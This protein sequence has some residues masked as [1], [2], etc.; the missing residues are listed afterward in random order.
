MS[1]LKEK[2]AEKTIYVSINNGK[3][4][5][6]QAD[7][8]TKEY[9]SVEGHIRKVDFVIEEYN[10]QKFEK[11]KFYINAVGELLILQIKTDSGYF[12]G[13]C[14]SLRS[15]NPK[16]LVEI[17]PHC[18]K[19]DGKVKTTCFVMQNGAAL[20]HFYT[21]NNAGDYP[22]LEVHEFK[23]KTMYDGTKQIEFWKKWLNETFV[24]APEDQKPSSAPEA[25]EL[26]TP[27]EDDLP[28]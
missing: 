14:N 5:V 11:A 2:K 17:Q 10:G 19:E 6:R 9:D 12:R 24:A 27:L 22:Q 16:E 13:L 21:K 18:S 28:F 23:G 25:P 8:S 1:G 7:K 15:G 4:V 26:N 20:K 3:L